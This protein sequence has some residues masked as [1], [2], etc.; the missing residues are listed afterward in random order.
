[1]PPL[2]KRNFNKKVF[3]DLA[4]S[5]FFPVAIDTFENSWRNPEEYV[6][7]FARIISGPMRDITAVMVVMTVY[8]ASVTAVYKFQ[9]NQF[10]NVSE[11]KK[12]LDN[13]REQLVGDLLGALCSE[14]ENKKVGDVI[15]RQ[16][17]SPGGF[18]QIFVEL[19]KAFGSE[20]DETQRTVY[21]N[22][23]YEQLKQKLIRITP[24]KS[25][26]NEKIKKANDYI[27]NIM[28]P[29]VF[30]NEVARGVSKVTSMNNP[31]DAK[32]AD[33]SSPKTSRSIDQLA[34]IGGRPWLQYVEQRQMEDKKKFAPILD[35]IRALQGNRL[36]NLPEGFKCELTQQQQEAAL[37]N[38]KKYAVEI[39]ENRNSSGGYRSFHAQRD[40]KIKLKLA[41][42]EEKLVNKMFW[43]EKDRWSLY[44]YDSLWKY[45]KF[46]EDQHCKSYR[47]KSVEQ[48]K[49][50]DLEKSKKPSE[51]SALLPR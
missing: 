36:P 19:F 38:L 22:Q 47:D 45:L 12:A 25:G 28:I 46:S 16:Q 29:E 42:F 5:S 39:K 9:N 6:R 24:F 48:L 40:E 31:K 10:Y 51:R 33:E 21:A 41:C 27:L 20:K 32:T 35:F 44:L 50:F 8:V 30:S 7:D 37:E 34:G 2:V 3:E 23:L 43:T 15:A 26:A 13:C 49:K 11:L 1:M 14:G 18:K 17:N 4:N